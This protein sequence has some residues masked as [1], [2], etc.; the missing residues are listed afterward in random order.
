[1]VYRKIMAVRSTIVGST[2]I[3]RTRA[4]HIL[5]EFDREVAVNEMAEKL[6]AAL[7]DRMEVSVLVN[8]VTL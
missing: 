8:R 5:I 2:G 3:R 1:M 7:S 4:G 6:K